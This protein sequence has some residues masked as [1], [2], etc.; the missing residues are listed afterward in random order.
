MNGGQ[1]FVT[2]FL[3]L[4]EQ[5]NQAVCEYLLDQELRDASVACKSFGGKFGDELAFRREVWVDSF[6]HD[7]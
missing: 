5:L 3:T 2:A 4:P 6:K 1:S 7:R